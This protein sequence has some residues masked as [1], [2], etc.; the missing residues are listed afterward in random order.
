MG[1]KAKKASKSSKGHY[2]K[3]YFRHRRFLNIKSRLARLQRS[4]GSEDKETKWTAQ[5]QRNA[6]AAWKI[7]FEEMSEQ[8]LE[9]FL[10]CTM[11]L[12]RA[13]LPWTWT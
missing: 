8:A 5:D 4:F 11:V 1:S 12:H 3:K 7:E 10:N 6:E 2:G 9:S 13:P